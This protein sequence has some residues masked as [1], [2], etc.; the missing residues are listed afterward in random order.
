MPIVKL[1]K[2][3]SLELEATACAWKG[4]TARKMEPGHVYYKYKPIVEITGDVK[5]QKQ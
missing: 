3:Q 2:G 5:T 1:I 4:K